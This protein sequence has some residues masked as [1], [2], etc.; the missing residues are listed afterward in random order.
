[1]AYTDQQIDDKDAAT[2]AAAT[3]AGLAAAQAWVQSACS[4]P[5]T[6]EKSVIG[7]GASEESTINICLTCGKVIGTDAP[8]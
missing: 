2:L 4:H 1:M 3:A 7:A 5:H 6:V 8:S